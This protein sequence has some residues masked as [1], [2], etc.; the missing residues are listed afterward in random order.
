MTD[1][2]LH[3]DIGEVKGKLDLLISMQATATK[4]REKTNERLTAVEARVQKVEWRLNS[5]LGAAGAIGS[6]VTFVALY[7]KEKIEALF[8]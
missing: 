7:F 4:D 8:S 5:A 3:Q 6:A 2:A 1:S